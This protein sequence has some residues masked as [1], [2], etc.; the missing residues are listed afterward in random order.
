MTER[1]E[2][3][4]MGWLPDLPDVN[5]YHVD[6]GKIKPMLAKV[7]GLNAPK[8]LP[9]C[10]DY[11]PFFLRGAEVVANDRGVLRILNRTDPSPLI[12]LFFI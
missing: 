10:V 9:G 12:Y 7:K 8:W 6:H 3:F 1:I 11:C 2:S 5:D 4:K